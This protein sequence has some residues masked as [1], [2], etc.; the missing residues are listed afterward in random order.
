[1]GRNFVGT[2]FCMRAHMYINGHGGPR[3]TGPCVH[4]CRWNS[5]CYFHM[6]ERG[7]PLAVEV[8]GAAAPAEAA[9]LEG[10]AGRRALPLY[11]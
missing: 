11:R 10:A 1:M 5:H 6:G 4:D 3:N 2:Y 8:M 9:C 7:G